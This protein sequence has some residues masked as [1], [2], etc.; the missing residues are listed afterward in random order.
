M[1]FSCA[2]NKSNKL[3]PKDL[4]EIKECLSRTIIELK[5]EKSIKR[6]KL[7][8]KSVKGTWT[9]EDEKIFFLGDW[10]IEVENNIVIAHCTLRDYP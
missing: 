1:L 5:H 2:P 9:K 4:A 6:F 3:S 8:I 10:V 7:N